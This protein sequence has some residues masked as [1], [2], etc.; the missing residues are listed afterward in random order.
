MLAG[1]IV[2]TLLVA[3]S[4]ETAMKTLHIVGLSTAAGIA[5]GTIAVQ[6]IH[7]QAKPPV[8]WVAV[9]DEV[10]DQATWQGNTGRSDAAVADILKPFGGL[11]IT[12][13]GQVT[14]VDGAAPKR[15]IITR[16]DTAENAKAWYNSPAQQKANETRLKATKSR[17][18]IVE[19]M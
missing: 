5:L 4:R 14:A 16:F 15:V 1:K 19:G 18:F 2:L 8:Y 9:V 12:R 7:A 10:T 11:Q 3:S 17:S 6:A 13:A